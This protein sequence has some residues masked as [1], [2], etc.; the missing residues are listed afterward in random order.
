MMEN[1]PRLDRNTLIAFIGAVIFLGVNFV[2]VRFSNQEL[3]PF[4]G[5]SLRFIIASSLLFGIVRLRGI[6]LPR[7]RALTGAALF[8]IFS[9]ALNFGFLY[10]ALTRVSAGTASVMF[11]TIPLFTQL[12]AALIGQEKLTF[13]GLLGA[14]IVIAGISVV[15][16]EQL[17]FDV[18]LVYLG[19]VLGGVICA[20]LSGII[21]RHYPRSNPMATNVV[22]MGLAAALLL[23]LSFL[24]GETRGLPS[25]TPTWL[26]L[27][28]LIL[29]SIVGF[30]L[31]VWLLSRW[32]AT[33]TSY[34][35]VLTPLVTVVTAALLGGETP[36]LTFLAGSVLVLIGVY[37]GAL[38][39]HDSGR[40]RSV[41]AD[42]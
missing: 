1:Q 23:L 30:V 36:T 22:G 7:G 15:F 25:L 38:A 20:A 6:S 32:S 29:S 17:R 42:G 2:A 40:A 9:F 14:F 33:A 12:I 5:A 26:A 16:L 10:W 13:R 37:V 41:R 24:A 31:I 34:I 39:P 19:A 35:G 3:P 28:W 11:A 18:P 4:W 21:V 27:G 8:G